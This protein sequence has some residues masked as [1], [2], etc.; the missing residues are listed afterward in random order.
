MLFRA[1]FLFTCKVAL[2]AFVMLIACQV[3][4]Q[5]RWAQLCER[6]SLRTT[7]ALCTTGAGIAVWLILVSAKMRCPICG[8]LGEFCT[9]ERNRP[10]INCGRCGL[11][12]AKNI[13]FSFQLEVIPPNGVKTEN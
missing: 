4:P 2:L 7:I 9:V 8:Q 11:V 12:F 13:A 5:Q 1:W 10:A 3:F 6:L